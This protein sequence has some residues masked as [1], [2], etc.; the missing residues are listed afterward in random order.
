MLTLPPA[1][2]PNKRPEV[3]AAVLPPPP[4]PPPPPLNAN[5]LAVTLL[6]GG[7]VRMEFDLAVNVDPAA[8]PATWVFGT[9]TIDSR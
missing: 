1:K 3:R 2:H 9:T 4:P 8:P 7:N 5:V 6:E